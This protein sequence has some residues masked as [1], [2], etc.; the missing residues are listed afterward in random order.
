[1]WG[2]KLVFCL[3]INKKVFYNLMA[4]LWVWVTRH[5]QSTQNKKLAI[6]VQH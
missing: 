3:Q 2:M 4:P 1:M 5:I 6:A